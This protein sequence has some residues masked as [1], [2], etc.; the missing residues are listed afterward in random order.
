MDVLIRMVWQRLGRGVVVRA[1]ADVVGIVLQDIDT[2]LP[3]LVNCL[4]GF[5][6]LSGMHINLAKI[7]GIPLWTKD[8]GE[9]KKVGRVVPEWAELPVD[10]K[11]M[12]LGCM[13]GPGKKGS[14][15]GVML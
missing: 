11:G 3:I 13:I 12:Y 5:G 14:T 6:A 7:V 15:S 10:S 9:A 8:M 1:F 4:E 2:R